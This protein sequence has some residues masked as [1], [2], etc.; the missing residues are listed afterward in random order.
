MDQ[1]NQTDYAIVFPERL[2]ANNTEEYREK[3]E[4]EIEHLPEG[5]RVVCDLK[6]TE[7]ISSRG[8]RLILM[9]RKKL[10]DMAIINVADSIYGIFEETGMTRIISIER[11]LQMIDPIQSAPLA[12][13]SNGEVYVIENDI[14]VKM[15]TEKTTRETI[16]EEWRNAKTA[17]MLGVPSVICYAMV[18]D[19]ERLGIMFERMKATSLATVIYSDY[20]HFDDYARRFS[21]LFKEMHGIRDELHELHSVKDA[22]VGLLEEADYLSEEEK[23]QMTAFLDAVPERDHVIHGDFHPNNIGENMGELILLD[24]AEIGYGHPLFDFM[25]S[26][27]DLILSGETT[28]KE[29]PE[30]TKQF[31]GLTVEELRK[32]WDILVENYFPGITA[33]KKQF[34]NETINRMLGF[35]LLLFPALHPNHPKEKH[36]AWIQLGRERFCAH[37]DEVMQRIGEMDA[38]IE[39]SLV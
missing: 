16:Y 1:A 7:Y 4:N 23:K 26:Y 15:F 34:F 36:D 29:H 9:L 10:K 20:E 31:F 33:E 28:G 14:I 35:K 39:E 21:G 3:F 19:G 30:I 32:L 25:A 24:L 8:L 18:T 6:D 5:T 11:R 2:D 13:G 27:Y 37:Y 22:F 12:R 38:M 17:F